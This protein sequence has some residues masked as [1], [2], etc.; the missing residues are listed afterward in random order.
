M[1]VSDMKKLNLD[2]DIKID[3]DVG[4]KLCDDFECVDAVA[5]GTP[6]TKEASIGN[7]T[8]DAFVEVLPN[9]GVIPAG[10]SN[11]TG[12]EDGIG[13]DDHDIVKVL[14][15]LD[16]EYSVSILESHVYV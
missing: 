5:E 13:G 1:A 12:E 14:R 7:E 6:V 8:E 2:Q 3:S 11:P 15:A 16:V 4:S 10:E 9:D